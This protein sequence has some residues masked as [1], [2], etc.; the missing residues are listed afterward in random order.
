[1]VARPVVSPS[2]SQL[3]SASYVFSGIFE[4]CHYSQSLPQTFP[5]S[6]PTSGIIKHSE[7]KRAQRT[8]TRTREVPICMAHMC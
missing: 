5:N 6:I 4:V 2:C 8:R 7:L 3:L 1:M